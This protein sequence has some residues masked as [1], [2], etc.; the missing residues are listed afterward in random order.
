MH[1]EPKKGGST[2]DIIIVKKHARFF[3]NFCFAVSRNKH[4]THLWKMYLS[5]L[6]NVLI[7]PCKNETMTFDTYNA[8]L[9]YDSLHQ[10]W[11]ETYESLSKGLW[12]KQNDS[13]KVCSKMSAISPNT[14]TQACWPL[15]NCVV[16]QR[17]LQ[18]M[19]NTQQTCRSS[20]MT[21]TLVS[22]T[23]CWVLAAAIN[24]CFQTRKRY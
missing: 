20:A 19:P 1:H 11:C 7:L 6:N 23:H 18:A 17:L 8:L 22:Y 14:R 15:V 10:A 13:H 3:Y 24:S 2:V 16:N 9:V 4:F 5:H 12:R 21:W